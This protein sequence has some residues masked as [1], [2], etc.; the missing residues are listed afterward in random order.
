MPAGKNF[1]SSAMRALTA[2]AVASALPLGESCTPIPV[3]GLPFRRAEVA[4]AWAPSSMRATSLS[5][6]VEPSGRARSTMLPNCSTLASCPLT[7]TVA[8]MLCPATFGKAPISPAETCAFCAR[9][10]ATTSAV[11]RF[12]PSSLAGSIQ[13]RM[14]R[15]VPN[16]CAWPTPGRRWISGTTL[17]AA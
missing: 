3:E 4:Y 16:N 12:R 17:R 1:S 2:S 15:S 13:T 5:R 10:A 14:A 11:L 7:T 9:I 8:A 6:T